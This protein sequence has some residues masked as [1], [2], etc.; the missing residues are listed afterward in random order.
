MRLSNTILFLLWGTLM[1]LAY[2]K[3]FF[4]LTIALAI[5][6]ALFI[7]ANEITEMNQQRKE[8]SEALLRTIESTMLDLLKQKNEEKK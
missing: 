4:N 2:Q 6:H 8:Q 7:I 5:T 1:T 3:P